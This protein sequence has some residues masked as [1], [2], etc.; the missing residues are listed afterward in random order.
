MPIL[1]HLVAVCVLAAASAAF[2]LPPEATTTHAPRAGGQVWQCA[3]LEYIIWQ[4]MDVPQRALAD[5]CDRAEAD[6]NW[7]AAY[8][9]MNTD[10]LAAAA[11]HEPH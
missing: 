3:Y 2:L 6:Q 8:G 1:R 7:V 5:A 9:A 10:T 4:E 11:V